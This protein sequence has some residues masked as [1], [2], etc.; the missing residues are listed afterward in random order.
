MSGESK[1]NL[2][3]GGHDHDVV[4]RFAGDADANS[5]LTQQGDGNESIVYNGQVED[6]EGD[7]IVKRD[8]DGRACVCTVNHLKQ[9]SNFAFLPTRPLVPK[10]LASVQQRISTLV[11]RSLLHTKTALDGRSP[12]IRSR[13]AN[14]GNIL[15]NAFRA[16][17][18]TDIALVNSGSVRESASRREGYYYIIDICPFDNSFIAKQVYSNVLLD[19]LENSLSDMHTDGRFLRRSG[20]RL[21]ASWGRPQGSR[22]LDA[23]FVPSSPSTPSTAQQKIDSTMMHIAMAAFIALGFDGYTCFQNEE[24]LIAEQSAMT[25]T[26][27]LRIFG[28]TNTTNTDINN[29]DDRDP[30]CYMY[31]GPSKDRIPCP[32][33]DRAVNRAHRAIVLGYNDRNHLPIVGPS[34]WQDSVCN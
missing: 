33:I 32:A 7:L 6:I 19:A 30:S 28:S 26:S 16:F 31:N 24:T 34:R 23:W 11:Q 8:D 10:I 9:S 20:L 18:D 14:L 13:E 27:L 21:V 12:V 5:A 29:D 17:Y 2:I 3:L 4:R 25:D 22:I 1:A 15:A